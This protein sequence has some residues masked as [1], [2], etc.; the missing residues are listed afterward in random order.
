MDLTSIVGFMFFKIL[1]LIIL[2]SASLLCLYPSSVYY[3]KENC[4]NPII[5]ITRM[6]F[7]PKVLKESFQLQSEWLRFEFFDHFST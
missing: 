3:G 2:N 1:I 5:N 6:T 7:I 4:S